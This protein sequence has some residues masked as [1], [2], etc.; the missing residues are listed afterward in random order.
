MTRRMSLVAML[1][2]GGALCVLG[3]SAGAEQELVKGAE[4]SKT[5]PITHGKP[6]RGLAA[7]LSAGGRQF[8]IGKPVPLFYGILN[9]GSLRRVKVVSPFLAADPNN[10]SWFTVTTAD[11]RALPYEGEF[12][13]RKAVLIDDVVTLSPGGFVGTG[14][15]DL[16]RAFNLKTLGKYRARWH[17]EM[18]EFSGSWAGHIVSNELEFEIVP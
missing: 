10:G 1:S 13:D 18:A 16:T 3:W 5:G 17:Y 7:F 9:D 11:G 4:D 8:K 6:D 15:S 14:S 12:I 2:V